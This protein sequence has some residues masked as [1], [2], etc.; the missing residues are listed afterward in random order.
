MGGDQI[1][2]QQANRQK[3]ADF[4]ASINLSKKR[5]MAI[6]P[7][8]RAEAHGQATK[9]IDHRIRSA[10]ADAATARCGRRFR[11]QCLVCKLWRIG[12]RE[13]R[14]QDR[15]DHGISHPCTEARTHQRK[16]RSEFDEEQNLWIAMTFQGGIA[17]FD[18]KTEKFTIYKLPPEMDGDY[19]EFT[20]VAANHNEVDGKVWIADAGTYVPLRLDLKTGKWESFE[21]FPKPRPNIYEITLGRAEQRL[22]QRDGPPGHRRDRRQDRKD[23]DL[24][25]AHSATRLRGAAQSTLKGSCGSAKIAATR[26]PCSTPRRMKFANGRCR[27]QRTSLTRRPPTSMAKLGLSRNSAT[28]FCASTPKPGNSPPT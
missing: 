2:Q 16:P 27:I 14:S 1:A 19:R 12:P 10:E 25:P 7:Q 6:S 15:Q 11:R 5:N 28:Q 22:V 24:S 17:K 23:F 20:F 13:A 26:S 4:L 9:V 3:L 8:D 21:V 18:R